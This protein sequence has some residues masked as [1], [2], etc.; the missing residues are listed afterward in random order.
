MSNKQNDE[1]A[2]NMM[3]RVNEIY[4]DENNYPMGKAY[5]NLFNA[6]HRDV[7]IEKYGSTEAQFTTIEEL[8]K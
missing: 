8:T 5:D 7:M 2:D 4:K 1:I 3:D 6:E